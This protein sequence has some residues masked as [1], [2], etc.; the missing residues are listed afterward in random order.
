MRECSPPQ[1]CHVSHVTCHV[2]RVTC[3]L[4]HVIFLF[5][6]YIFFLRKKIGQSGGASRW[7][8]CYQRGLPRL[9][10]KASALWAHAFYESEFPSVC[11]FGCL[12][13]CLFTFEVPFKQCFAPTSKNWMSK[14][15][16]V[17]ESLGKSNGK[18][19]SH[20]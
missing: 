18:K 4:S 16:R 8:V 3:H 13:V 1:T 6:I 11:L 17:S 10:F 14:I 15:F 19:W 20:I 2:S 12:F 7:R 5:Y 9:V